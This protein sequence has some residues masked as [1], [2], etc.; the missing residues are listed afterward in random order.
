[1]LNNIENLVAKSV[2]GSEIV[3][4][5]VPLKKMQ[6]KRWSHMFEQLKAYL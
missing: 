2:N 4:S 6:S 3:V 5:L 1:M